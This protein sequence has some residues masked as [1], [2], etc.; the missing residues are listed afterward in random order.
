MLLSKITQS[1]REFIKRNDGASGIEYALVAGMVA[2]AIA[3]FVPTIS[4]AIS[5][6]FTTILN[7]LNAV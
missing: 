3:V 1:V 5:G 4:S 2:V 7:T 6:I